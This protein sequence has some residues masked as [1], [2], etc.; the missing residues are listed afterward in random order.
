M[1][2]RTWSTRSNRP[3]L[4]LAGK[5]L[6]VWDLIWSHTAQSHRAFR[7]RFGCWRKCGRQIGNRPVGCREI[8]RAGEVADGRAPPRAQVRDLGAEPGFE[9]SQHRSVIES[10]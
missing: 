6:R 10:M 8:K 3:P 5:T 1:P 7:N 9:E 4:F 2:F